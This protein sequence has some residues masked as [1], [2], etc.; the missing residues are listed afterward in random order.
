MF[1]FCFVFYL[2]FVVYYQRNIMIHAL[3]ELA[4]SIFAE[5]VYGYDRIAK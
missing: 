2:K 4:K 3:K 1:L 5:H